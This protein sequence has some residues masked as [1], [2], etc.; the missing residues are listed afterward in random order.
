LPLQVLKYLSGSTL[1]AKSSE[2]HLAALQS[3]VVVSLET[4]KTTAGTVQK[5]VPQQ[6]SSGKEVKKGDSRADGYDDKQVAAI[7]DL[8]RNQF[9]AN[10]VGLCGCAGGGEVA[11]TVVPEGPV[12]GRVCES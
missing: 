11:S 10:V 6:Q 8:I 4:F 3:K 7:K 12:L 2:E 5:Y 1:G 9:G